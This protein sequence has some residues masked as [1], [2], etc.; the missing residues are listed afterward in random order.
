[1]VYAWLGIAGV[2]LLYFDILVNITIRYPIHSTFDYVFLLWL[3][4]D[5]PIVPEL[6]VLL[7]LLVSNFLL[8]L[9]SSRIVGNTI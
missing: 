8:L 9:L 5:S 4:S 6:V 1:M 7:H 2:G 3:C